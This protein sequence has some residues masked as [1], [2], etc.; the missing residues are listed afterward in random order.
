MNR[1]RSILLGLSLALLFATR[2][3]SADEGWS[4]SKLNP[5]S[6]TSSTKSSP[7]EPRNFN[8]SAK[9]SFRKTEPSTMDKISSG[10]KSM[11][12]KTKT[13]L[14]P[15][16]SKVAKPKPAANTVQTKSKDGQKKS[17]VPSWLSKKEEPKTARTVPEFLNQPRPK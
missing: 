16:G 11:V 1:T 14:T 9:P 13:A 12:N 10:T 5:F 3:F 2:G 6:K 15:G 8:S 17:W 7:P 4:L